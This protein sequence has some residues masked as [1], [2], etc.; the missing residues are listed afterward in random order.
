MIM[1]ILKTKVYFC[2]VCWV[3]LKAGLTHFFRL[4]RNTFPGI[5]QDSQIHINPAHCTTYD[6][7][8]VFQ[9]SEG[10]V[11]DIFLG[12]SGAGK[13]LYKIPGHNPLYPQYQYT[14][15]PHC[16]LYISYQI[17]KDNFFKNRAS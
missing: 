17:H 2:S 12:F 14:N 1:Y 15:S 7:Q 16:S 11:R 9:D 3:I 5:F 6:N 13:F 8:P 4:F 10:L